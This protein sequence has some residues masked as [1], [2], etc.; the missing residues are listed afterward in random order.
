MVNSFDDDEDDFI[1]F[2]LATAAP[3]VSAPLEVQAV[4][5]H[6]YAAVEN[7]GTDSHRY[8]EPPSDFDD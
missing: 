6:H 7:D 2:D 1:N 4:I 3:V 5:E 8:E